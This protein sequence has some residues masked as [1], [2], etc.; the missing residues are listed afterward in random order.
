MKVRID[1]TIWGDIGNI[2]PPDV[3][4][5]DTVGDYKAELDSV[6]HNNSLDHVKFNGPWEEMSINAVAP[7]DEGVNEYGNILNKWQ[8]E[9]T[10]RMAKYESE[11]V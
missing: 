1:I 10:R 3:L 8:P 6:I 11:E 2:T 4:N 9:Y 7:Y 5:S